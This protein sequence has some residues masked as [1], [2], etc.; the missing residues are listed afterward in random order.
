MFNNICEFWAAQPIN[1]CYRSTTIW[2]EYCNQ[3][4][5]IVLQLL[6]IIDM[7]IW[8]HV[9]R[10]IA[11]NIGGVIT[12]FTSEW[13]V[14]TCV[15]CTSCQLLMLLSI[16]TIETSNVSFQGRPQPSHSEIFANRNFLAQKYQNNKP[17]NI[18]N[19][20]FQAKWYKIFLSIFEKLN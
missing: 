11:L 19:S 2:R 3:Y 13:L 10:K 7:F 18:I 8:A 6:R 14:S 4:W 15:S 12:Y 9:D 17:L 1:F 20:I 5:V 16:D